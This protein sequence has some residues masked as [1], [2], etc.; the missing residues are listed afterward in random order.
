MT[1]FVDRKEEL[2]ALDRLASESRPQF[3]I[4]FG[5]RRLG[6]TTLL[7]EFAARSGL[8]ALYW[9]ASK[10]SEAVLQRSLYETC[11]RF[12]DIP[13]P[14]G[15]VT[16]SSWT[17]IFQFLAENIVEKFGGQRVL[18]I[19]DE[20][21]YA[22]E[23]SAPLPS[24]LQ[25]AWDHLFKP[26]TNVLLCIA[27]SHVGMM[28]DL[29]EHQAPLYGRFTAQFPVGPLP[30]GALA[31]FF[32]RMTAAERVGM[33]AILGGVPAYLERIIPERS[34]RANLEQEIMVAT[35]IFRT[36]A[37]HSLQEDLRDTHSYHSILQAIGQGYHAHDEIALHS[38][39]ARTS[40]PR[41]LHRLMALGYVDRR[42]PATMPP[43]QRG[44]SRQSR[45]VLTDQFL[46]FFYRF[47]SPNLVSIEQGLFHDLWDEISQHLR[48]FVGATAFEELCRE[49][50]RRQ[51]VAE[52]LAFHPQIIGT[53]WSKGVQVDVVAVNWRTRQILLGECKWGVDAVSRS[54]VRDLVEIK[55]GRVLEGLPD[56]GEG[57]T[58][59][60]AFFA[61]AGL[62]TAAQELAAAHDAL[63][64]D[65]ACLDRDLEA[66]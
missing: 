41:Y 60:Y 9:V 58:A 29:Q 22:V 49:W 16:P 20:F 36:E 8:P 3:V 12:L 35:G 43:E 39:V 19:L 30:F 2:A 46:R 13:P 21:P 62:T 50:I 47:I 23:A 18:V 14:P 1:R 31:E 44:R 66:G 5:R 38:G 45:Y 15:M 17:G 48:A 7:L 42:L 11:A 26:R 55:S 59:Y 40:L 4:L 27:G 51:A 52:R 24:E 65:L 53:H 54:V 33:Y 61:R 25:N 64:I 34:L 37:F 57:W 10:Q 28:S 56:A 6:K 32:P 63:I